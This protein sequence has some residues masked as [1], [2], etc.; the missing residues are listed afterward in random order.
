[1]K[2]IYAPSECDTHYLGRLTKLCQIDIV[3]EFIATFD[4][5]VIYTKALSDSFF[6]ECFISDLKEE[7]RAQFMM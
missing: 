3:I 6:K 5:L 2:T 4:K 1:M 7:I